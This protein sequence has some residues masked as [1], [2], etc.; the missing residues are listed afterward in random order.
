MVDTVIFSF[1]VKWTSSLLLALIGLGFSTM[2]YAG[3]VV[4]FDFGS[5][6][7][8][9]KVCF[10]LA[11]PL[12]CAIFYTS[13]IASWRQLNSRQPQ[14][15]LICLSLVGVFCIVMGIDQTGIWLNSDF[16]NFLPDVAYSM[17]L[18]SWLV[19]AKALIIFGLIFAIPFWANISRMPRP[20]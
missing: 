7:S 2:V 12:A 15:I 20:S 6:S 18:S 3:I 19:V 5:Y 1:V 11:L 17:I 14:L 9:R 4:L 10:L 13:L 16:M 8:I